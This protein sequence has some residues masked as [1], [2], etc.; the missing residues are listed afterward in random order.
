MIT[1]SLSD[2]NEIRLSKPN[3]V[4]PTDVINIYNKLLTQLNINTNIQK[5][6]TLKKQ[7][8]WHHINP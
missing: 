5:Q 1:Y 4:L 2:Y 7:N 6:E 8:Q 3:N